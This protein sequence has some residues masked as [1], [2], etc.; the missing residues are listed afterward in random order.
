M[1]KKMDNNSKIIELQSKLIE[2]LEEIGKLKSEINELRKTIKTT[3]E[4]KIRPPEISTKQKV[5]KTNN[6]TIKKPNNK[7]ANN[8]QIEKAVANVI[9]NDLLRA[10]ENI[11][12]LRFSNFEF[13]P[14]EA[15]KLDFNSFSHFFSKISSKNDYEIAHFIRK[16]RAF[17]SDKSFINKSSTNTF[18]DLLMK[19]LPYEAEEATFKKMAFVVMK[20]LNHNY[21]KLLGLLSL[22]EKE[23]I[24]FS[25]GESTVVSGLI[26]IFIALFCNLCFAMNQIIRIKGLTLLVLTSKTRKDNF[27]KICNAIKPFL[28]TFLDPENTIF[29]FVVSQKIRNDFD[30]DDEWSIEVA[31]SLV[32]T[33]KK[34]FLTVSGII[35][36]AVSSNGLVATT[37]FDSE[38]NENVIKIKL[39]FLALPGLNEK[40]MFLERDFL[41]LLKSAFVK[42]CKNLEG[43]SIFQKQILDLSIFMIC[44]T[45]ENGLTSVLLTEEFIH[46]NFSIK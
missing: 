29:D 42:E 34:L 20:I 3:E 1:D 43:L 22:F 35:K 28:K 15:K 30:K 4:P 27:H 37:E 46:N 18:F 23:A 2:A 5:Q 12:P 39:I 26:D 24:S 6:L 13:P 7:I 19:S 32:S 45:R 9:N 11:P 36:L 38:L 17:L 21:Y 44:I 8:S 16:T 25:R 14:L 33:L 41:S 10:K 31:S 40:V